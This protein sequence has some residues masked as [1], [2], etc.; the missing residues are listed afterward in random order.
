MPWN[1]NRPELGI[2]FSNSSIH[3]KEGY[4]HIKPPCGNLN[5]KHHSLVIKSE[6][7]PHQIA[8][9]P[10]L[11]NLAT[12]N[13]DCTRLDSPYI[14]SLSTRASRVSII[15]ECL[16]NLVLV[17]LSRNW[18]KHS[19][20]MRH[21]RLVNIS[22]ISCRLNIKPTACLEVLMV[23]Y[24]SRSTHSSLG[25]LRLLSIHNVVQYVSERSI[26]RIR[27]NRKPV[28]TIR[29]S[30]TVARHE[31]SITRL[32]ETSPKHKGRLIEEKRTAALIVPPGTRQSESMN[33]V[34]G[35]KKYLTYSDPF[36]PLSRVFYNLFDTRLR[37][38]S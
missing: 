18:L 38:A 26:S 36:N 8:T 32:P 13:L 15:P 29:D 23:P 2:L 22:G 9:S 11:I 10:N 1:V 34:I 17:D 33:K 3:G 19:S 28:M 25:P 12:V 5:S 24:T 27:K 37:A 7:A 6:L 20:I 14:V 16:R 4:L 35:S 31:P 21:I 30:N